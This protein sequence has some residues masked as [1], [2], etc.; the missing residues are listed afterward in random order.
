MVRTP[1]KKRSAENFYARF[2]KVNIEFMSRIGKQPISLPNNV[3]VTLSERAISV[4]GPKG[5]LSLQ[6]HPEIVA[7]KDD[8]G[9]TVVFKRRDEQ[10]K[11]SAALWG[12]TRALAANMVHG[13]SDGFSKKLEIEGVGYRAQVQGKNLVLLLGFSHPVEFPI[14]EGIL[15]QVEGNKIEVSGIDKQLVGQ[16]AAKIRAFKKPE[17]YKGKGIHYAGEHIRR[18]AG[19][20]AAAVATK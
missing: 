9:K 2:T 20:K 19:K 13:V 14:P 16:V 3:E 6:L 8:S 11:G 7:E 17:P 12:L 18:K 1:K 10:V 4:R 5:T 15:I